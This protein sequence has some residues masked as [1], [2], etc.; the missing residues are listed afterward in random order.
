M[1]YGGSFDAWKNECGNRR[2]SMNAGEHAVTGTA[3]VQ[4]AMCK[5]WSH[6]TQ[7]SN[8]AVG[9]DAFERAAVV[10]E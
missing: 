4:A 7:C 8:T 1:I 10:R 5:I 3:P 2:I 6:R 9:R